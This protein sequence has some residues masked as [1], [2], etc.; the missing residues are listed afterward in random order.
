MW[1]P[2]NCHHAG[3]ASERRRMKRSNAENQSHYRRRIREGRV[4]LTAIA[5]VLV[6][7][8]I[9]QGLHHN[10]DLAD[11]DQLQE[12]HDELLRLLMQECVSS[13]G[14]D[15]ARNSELIMNAMTITAAWKSK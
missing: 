2:R 9:S 12:A 5:D 8:L 6:A 7:V 3:S 10:R 4:W 13:N 11:P 14:N 15:I 1:S